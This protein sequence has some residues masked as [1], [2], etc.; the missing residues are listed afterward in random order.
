VKEVEAAARPLGNQIHVV[1][2]ST[3]AEIDAAFSK[4]VQLRVGALIIAPDPLQ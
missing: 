3:D 2:A 4:L 1:E